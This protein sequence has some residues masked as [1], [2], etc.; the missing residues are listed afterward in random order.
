MWGVIRVDPSALDVYYTGQHQRLHL[1]SQLKSLNCSESS[2]SGG[3]SRAWWAGLHAAA[4]ENY[5]LCE[6]VQ[7]LSGY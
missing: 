3:T 7:V 4:S 2:Y 1:L 6:C 5:A